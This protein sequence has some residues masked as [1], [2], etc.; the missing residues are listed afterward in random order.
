MNRR[1]DLCAENTQL[2]RNEEENC[3]KGWIRSDE[4]FGPVLDMKVCKTLGRYSVE[5]EVPSLFEDQTTTWI[6]IV[7][8]AE[9]YVRETM[10]IQEEERASGKPV[11]IARPISKPSPASNWNF[12]PMGQ[13]KWI[14]I[15]VKRSKDPYFLASKCQNSLLN[16]F[17]TRISL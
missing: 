4:R 2:P 16:D 12:I 17:D 11:A 13:R 1:F 7:N 8:G 10:P 15:E 14:D 6:R 3:A 9:K 5:V